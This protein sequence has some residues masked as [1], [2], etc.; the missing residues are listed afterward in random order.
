MSDTLYLVDTFSLIFQVYYAIRQPMTGT[1]GQ[2]TNAVYGFTGDIEHLL[3]EKQPTHLIC[4]VESE[5]PTERLALFPEY[6]AGRGEMP[7]DLRPQIPLIFDVLQGYRIP[8]VYSDGW[9][10]DDVIATLATK[11]AAAGMDVRIVSTDKDFR[12]LIGPKIKLYSIRKRQFYDETELMQEWGIR[13][14][15]VV[16][17]QALVGDSVDNIPGVPGVGPK[18]AS[19]LLHHFGTLEGVLA[20][21]DKA[22]GKKLAENLRDYADQARLSK[23]LVTLRTDLPLDIDWQAARV[24]PPDWD[25]L[26]QLFTDLGFRRY[27]EEARQHRTSTPLRE[28]RDSDRRWRTI[29]T[30]E[31]FSAFVEQLR[32]QRTF[33]VDLET[34]STDPLRAD[35]VGWAF[36][37]EAH[38]SYYLPVD[39]PPGSTT[40]PGPEVVAA[41]KPILEDPRREIINQNVKY[42]VLVLRRAGIQ[43]QNLGVDPMVADYLLDAGARSHGLDELAKRHLNRKMI[44]I[45]DL[46]GTGQHQLKMFEVDVERAAEYASEDADVAWQLAHLLGERLRQQGLW[47]LYWNLERPLILVLAEM[48][49][50]GVRVD[51]EELHR[52]SAELTARLDALIHEIHALAGHEFNIASP[53]QLAKVLFEELKL[54]VLKRTKTGPSTNEEVLER[55]AARHPLPAKIMQHRMISKLKGTYLDALP[56]LVHPETGRLHTSFSQVAAATGRLSSSDPNLQNIPIRTVEG[57]RIRRAFLPGAPGWKLI[58]LDYSQIEL[59]MLAHFS[60]DAALLEAFRNGEDIHRKVAADVFNVPLA[61]VAPEQRR[62]AKAVNFGVVYGQTPFGLAAMLGID[63]ADAA[64]FIDDYFAR[65]AGVDRFIA[66]TL[67]ECRRTGYAVT[68]LGRRRAIDG[69]RPRRFRN[70]NLPERTAINT[71]IQGS[72]ADLIKQ[73]MVR[74]HARMQREAAPGRLLLQIH[75]ELVFEA[76]AD[77]VPRVVELAQHEMETALDLRVPIEVDVKIGDNWLDAAGA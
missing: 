55:L 45:T 56:K 61:E 10:A 37:W 67:E 46:I 15:Q 49:W 72:A 16:D 54:P 64:E 47:D 11:A 38:S 12:Q 51:V 14:D 62:I 60:Q 21:W 20:N 69:I 41:L 27:A 30:P 39:G 42:D 31:E 7:D 35:I 18:K 74:I 33:C 68:L 52:Q 3:Q 34:T 71:V 2:P 57:S 24:E 70:L 73:A 6:K 29:A 65:Y 25:R 4:A 17:F 9:E 76:P 5:E 28:A 43:V 22:P 44:P 59:R 50:N 75:D 26:Y 8:I 63:E 40:L 53:K 77:D 23:Q 48:E 32:A 19:I 58:C 36:C 13:P 66:E 1:R